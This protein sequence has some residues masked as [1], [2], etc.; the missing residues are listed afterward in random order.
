VAGDF[1]VTDVIDDTT[2]VLFAV[3]HRP[4][5]TTAAGPG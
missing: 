2:L 3:A 1:F 4:R 5:R